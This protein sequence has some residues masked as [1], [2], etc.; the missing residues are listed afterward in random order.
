LKIGVLCCIR[1]GPTIDVDLGPAGLG[2]VDFGN[3]DFPTA[4]GIP[5]D[6]KPEFEALAQEIGDPATTVAEIEARFRISVYTV[7]SA[8]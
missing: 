5:A 2:T 8:I 6:W 7:A 4:I 3:H 1:A